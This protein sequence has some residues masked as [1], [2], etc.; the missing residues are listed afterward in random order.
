MP[1][2]NL[3]HRPEG[4]SSRPAPSRPSESF[5]STG[6]GLR[7]WVVRWWDGEGGTIGSLLR[8]LTLPLEWGFRLGSG[9][10]N[11]FY[12]RGILPLQRAPVPVI[13]VGNLTVGG[14]GKTPFAAWLLRELR[15]R[16]QSPALV[17]SGYGADEIALHRRWNPD[18]LVLAQEDR[19]FG[20]WK[21][22]RKGAT[23]VVLDDGFQHRRL[24]REMDIVIVAATTPRK[25]RLLPRGPFREP[26]SSMAR[27]ALV[28]ISEKA[29]ED[30]TRETERR[31]QPYLHSP[32]VVV[33]FVPDRWTDLEGN[34]ADPPT[35][36]YL[37]VCGIG[38]PLGF[39]RTLR[40]A[41]G[42]PG[43]ILAYP[44]HHDYTWSDVLDI[45]D[46]LAGRD[47]VTTEKDAVRMGTFREG[48]AGL[49]VLCLR[50][51]V[52]RGEEALWSLVDGFLERQGEGEGA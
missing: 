51:E 52:R 30:A 32:P 23:V 50:M 38:D 9:V 7:E 17:A 26:L 5:P 47:L 13:S 11:R 16:G 20:A 36:D 14:S 22:A 15:T 19:A 33:S 48:L 8:F 10:R 34:D 4:R 40:S 37:G 46:R 3:P 27:A 1:D 18:C 35:G 25:V 29:E 44:D 43:E 39:S 28:V 6:S 45:R 41:L 49:K 12:D 2:R 21:A 31:L 24:R 42:R